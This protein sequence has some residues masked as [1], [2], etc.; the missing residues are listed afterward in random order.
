MSRRSLLDRWLPEPLDVKVPQITV[1]FWVIKILTTG[2][3]EALS[4]DLAGLSIPLAIVVGLG[5][6]VL[7]LWLQL[8][9]RRYRAVTY[10][11]A[12]AMIAV[13]GTMVA[14]GIHLVGLPYAATTAFYLT[15][16]VG[17]FA[18]WRR[19]E[20]TLSIHSIT[21]RRREL[22]YWTTVLA[23]F[24]LGT[25]AGDLTANQL[26]LGY[27]T[28]AVIF[29]VAIAV[30]AVAWRVFGA[31]P[32]ATFWTAYVLTR[33]LGASLADWFGKPASRGSGLGYGDGS[34]AA[35][36]ATVIIV[37]VVYVTVRRQDQQPTPAI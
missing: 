25:A 17:L 26:H 33:P 34:V 35:I 14:D 22:M 9:R 37:L 11:F 32:V 29:V 5:G 28:S 21:T 20:G 2:M 36:A 19:T 18:W 8:R 12:V 13:F 6:F 24:A 1:V 3:G 7:A 16:V 15:V 30:P 4:D 23:T 27:L 10:W 31:S